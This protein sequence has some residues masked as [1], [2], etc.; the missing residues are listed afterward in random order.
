[1]HST[2]SVFARKLNVETLFRQHD[3]LTKNEHIHGEQT[4]QA[5]IRDNIPGVIVEGAS[6]VKSRGNAGRS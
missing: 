1:M 4:K 6:E 3:A 2:I 5:R